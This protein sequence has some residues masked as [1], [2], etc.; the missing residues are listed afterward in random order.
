MTS[1]IA[2]II[3]ILIIGI[4]VDELFGLADR[5]IRRR[6]GLAGIPLGE[7]AP[8]SRLDMP[9]VDPGGGEQF[10]AGARAGQPPDGEVGD[11]QPMRPPL[12]RAS[13]TA[14]PSPPAG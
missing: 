4:I 10:G 9:G 3:V 11:G 5:A 7:Q 12:V 14:D 6:W 1:A 8:G 13:A 2:I